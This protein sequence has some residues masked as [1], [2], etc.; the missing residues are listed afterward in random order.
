MKT[1]NRFL[2]EH[3]GLCRTYL[4][5]GVLCF[6]VFALS[7]EYVSFLTVYIADLFVLFFGIRVITTASSKLLKEPLEIL[8]Q[9]CDPLPFLEET[10]HQMERKDISPQRQLTQ[11]NYATALRMVGDNDQAA[12]ILEN[13]N[14]D[15]YAGVTPQIK[16]VYYNNL[17]DVLFVLNRTTEALI[18]H[19][20]ARQIYEDLPESKIK[21]SLTQTI[22]LSEAEALY[23]Q[24]E[25][26]KALHKVTWINCQSQRHL[27]D[28]ALLAAK[29][30]IALEEP[31][32][33][34]EKLCY[35]ADHGNKLA[36]AQEAKTLL[37]T[38]A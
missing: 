38:L 29:C 5:L 4:F 31:E 19:K 17:S 26:D 28:A 1:V 34:R 21:Q 13:I 30:H 22:Q 14:I 8:E 37:E 33:A 2:A 11:M 36:V 7:K 27:M 16:F 24:H 23:Y 9:Q 12:E 20:K 35:V 18:W 15:R 32:K 6:T 25:Y 3:P 10:R